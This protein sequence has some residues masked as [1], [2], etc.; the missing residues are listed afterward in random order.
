MFFPFLHVNQIFYTL[1]YNTVD[2]I[3]YIFTEI[4]LLLTIDILIQGL[5][6]YH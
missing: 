4:F 1:F 3:G 2:V 5:I 6:F